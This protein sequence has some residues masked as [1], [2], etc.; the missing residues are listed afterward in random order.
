MLYYCFICIGVLFCHTVIAGNCSQTYSSPSHIRA[1]SLPHQR[2]GYCQYVFTAPRH[3]RIQLNF[4]QLYGFAETKNDSL[5]PSPS[6]SASSSLALPPSSSSASSDTMSSSAS[7]SSLSPLSSLSSSPTS[8]SPKFAPTQ[9]HK[10]MPLPHGIS[11]N[12]SDKKAAPPISPSPF[13]SPCMPKIEIVEVANNGSERTLNVI[14]DNY[15]SPKVFQS[16]Y[17][18][19]LKLKYSW[20]P[21]ESSGF[22]LDFDFLKSDGY[23]PFRCYDGGCLPDTSLVCNDFPDC[24]D[25]SDENQRECNP[26]IV[27]TSSETVGPD[28]GA[29]ATNDFVQI[30]V[31]VLSVV[32]TIGVVSCVINHYRLSARMFGRRVREPSTSSE[33]HQLNPHPPS[34]RQE[35][36]YVPPIPSTPP[37]RFER[38]I[39]MQRERQIRYQS[40]QMD[41]DMELPPSIPISEDG[42]EG[43]V[44]SRRLLQISAC[45][46]SKELERECFRPPPN[47]TIFDG[48]SPPPYRSHSAGL[49]EWQQRRKAPS[50]SSSSSSSMVGRLVRDCNSTPTVVRCNSLSCQMHSNLRDR[51]LVQ[52]PCSCTSAS[53]GGGGGEHSRHTSGSSSGS[54]NDLPPEYSE[55]IANLEAYSDS[56]LTNDSSLTS[57][58]GAPLTSN[59]GTTRSNL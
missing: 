35:V 28:N 2:S 12:P 40:V 13:P 24:R 19:L 34:P 23:C 44:T 53:A 25:S 22:T 39:A 29:K 18:H 38:E 45:N 32:F 36:M 51:E 37:S 1:E 41:M 33:Q 7:A 49:L 50:T 55:V 4:T 16:S 14:C 21:G 15:G 47:K 43:Y 59:G 27:S 52:R 26:T 17:S 8:L 10:A 54:R 3:Q 48:E 31:I 57:S 9:S 58:S 6:S 11:A 30:I 5:L 46:P 42:E 56:S 20:T